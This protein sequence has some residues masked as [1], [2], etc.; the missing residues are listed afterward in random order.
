MDMT[1]YGKTVVAAVAC[2]LWL[3]PHL[4]SAGGRAGN[5][6]AIEHELLS[7]SKYVYI[8]SERK[9]G[10]F[11]TAAEIWF[12]FHDDAV[13]V[14]TRPDSWR[15]RRIRAGR[16]RAKIAIGKADGLTFHAEGEI[17][18]DPKVEELLQRSY[19]LKYPDS[20]PKYAEN[21]RTGFADGSRVL[22]RYAPVEP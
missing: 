13:F 10:A 2:A 5:L 9:D 1:H 8:S 18:K 14:G 11:G 6:G 12:L 7:N 15:A 3:G 20:W 16:T 17:V 22:I 21:F 19:A 4:A